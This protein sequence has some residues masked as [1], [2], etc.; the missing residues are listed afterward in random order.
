[1]PVCWMGAADCNHVN[2]VRAG[3]TTT[4]IW[5]AVH[6][7]RVSIEVFRV[8]SRWHR[9]RLGAVVFAYI[10]CK[11]R[12][13]MIDTVNNGVVATGCNSCTKQTTR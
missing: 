4:N 13:S 9:R 8:V 10:C 12:T 3:C 11:V 7:F 2:N 5:R 6:M 1:M